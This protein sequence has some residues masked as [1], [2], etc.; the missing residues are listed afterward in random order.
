MGHRQRHA[1]LSGAFYAREQVLAGQWPRNRCMGNEIAGKTLG[2]VGYGNIARETARLARAL[3]MRVLA[4]DPYLA[5][6][7]PAWQVRER[8]EDLNQL[9]AQ[10][11]AVSLHVPL[12]ASTHHLID[13]RPWR[14]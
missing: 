14:P 10:A 4:F 2:L 6:E 11:D 1:A 3:G 12:N 5:P 7:D 8:L 9:L 13:A